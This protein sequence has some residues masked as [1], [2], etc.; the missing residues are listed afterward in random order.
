MNA[1]KRQRYLPL[2]ELQPGMVLAKPILLSKRGV[3]TLKLQNGVRLDRTLLDQL[4][5]H[6]AEYACVEIEE[7]QNA[8]AHETYALTHEERLQYLFRQVNLE[9]PDNLELFKQ[10]LIYRCQ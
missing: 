4:A 9:N 1:M 2:D 8:R 6:Q 5:A 10:L 3:V 7:H